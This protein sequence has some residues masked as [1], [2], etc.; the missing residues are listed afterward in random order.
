MNLPNFVY[1]LD[2]P[3]FLFSLPLNLYEASRFV[4]RWMYAPDRHNGQRDKRT[5]KGRV[6]LS[7]CLFAVCVLDGV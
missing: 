5:N 2:D 6:S 3:G 1:F 4:H 7:V